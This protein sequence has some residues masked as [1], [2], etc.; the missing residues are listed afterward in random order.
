V[1]VDVHTAYYQSPVSFLH[2]QS[3]I[4]ELFLA[5]NAVNYLDRWEPTARTVT[6]N[7]ITRY[8]KVRV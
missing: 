2:I 7:T 5:S 8:T 3:T 1:C 4:T 6:G